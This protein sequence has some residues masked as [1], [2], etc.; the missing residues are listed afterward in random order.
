MFQPSTALQV[1]LA[2]TREYRRHLQSES[3]P[4]WSRALVWPASIALLLGAVTAIAAANR[5]S[6]RLLASQTV[7][8]SFVAAVQVL[9]GLLLIRS[10]PQRVVGT[11]RA[12]DLFFAGHL[13]WSLWLVAA[14]GLQVGDPSNMTALL[15]SLLLPAAATPRILAA[16]CREVLGLSPSAA[17]RRVVAH[18]LVTW[19]IILTYAEIVGQLALRVWGGGD[20]S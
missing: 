17:R 16:F 10:A 7:C 18:Q 2:P 4:R 5:V 8:W 6:V 13:P 19:L 14:A 12:L 3:S 9:T 15:V 1:M 20:A 11:L